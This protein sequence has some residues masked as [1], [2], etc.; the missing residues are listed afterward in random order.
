MG[1]EG[2]LANQVKMV[3]GKIIYY[4]QLIVE[5]LDHSSISK[6]SNKI[7]FRYSKESFNYYLKYLRFVQ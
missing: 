6:V 4:P 1:E 5:H 3:E 7:L 2:V